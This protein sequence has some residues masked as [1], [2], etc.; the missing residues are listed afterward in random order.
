MSTEPNPE[1]LTLE[2]RAA[3]A[4]SR[5]V[6]RGIARL[7]PADMDLLGAVTGDI[8]EI[9]GKRRTVAKVMPAFKEHRGQQVLQIDGIIRD[10]AGI[11]L[12]DKVIAQVIHPQLATFVQLTPVS[13]APRRQ[14]YNSYIGKLIDGLAVIEGD[15]IRATMFG[16][17]F[18]EFK[19]N[20]TEPKGVVLIHPATGFS[21]TDPKFQVAGT[22]E[23]QAKIA[24]EDI[25]GLRREVE[26]LRELIEFPL[27]HPVIF[28]RLGIE[29][30]RGLL[31]SGPPG[32]GK[33]LI[34]RVIAQETNAHFISI[35][36]PEL[37]H[38]FYGESDV[39]LRQVFEEATRNQPAI[40][41]I[42]EIDAI[43]PK[44]ELIY[45]EIEKR[46]IGQLMTLMDGLRDR[47]QIIVIG[48]TNVPHA[49]NPALRRPG[50]FD[51]EIRLGI[52]NVSG[53]KEILEIHSRGMPLNSEVNLNELAS[54]T[55]GF[56]GADLHSL[57]REAA[58]AA[59]RRTILAVPDV[60]S[61]LIEEHLSRMRVLM[62]DFH[63]AMKLV[64]PSGLRGIVVEAPEV[65]W[66]QVGGLDQ[67]RSEL[68]R[69]VLFPL[70]H[71]EAFSR[72]GVRPTR[73]VLLT[74]PP[75]SGKTLVARALAHAGGTNFIS[76]RSS[77]L[78]VRYATESERVIEDIFRQARQAIPCI[79]FIDEIDL[80]MPG[81]NGDRSSDTAIQER[82]LAQL[83]T[84]LDGIEEL[85]GIIVIAATNRL[86]RIDVAL[87]RPGRFDVVQ[88]I[89]LPDV[90]GLKAIFEVYLEG[91]PLGADVDIAALAYQA[92]GMT[93]AD[94]E[95]VCRLA[96]TQTI[97]QA[98]A[99]GN[100][101]NSVTPLCF[102]HPILSEAIE[103]VR[104]M[105]YNKQTFF[106][107]SSGTDSQ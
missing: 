62:D 7:D 14:A 100:F 15:R 50:R 77:E 36:G 59:L 107:P 96:A 68:T 27:R 28:E 105:R 86:D 98:T 64:E 92:Q 18:Q 9:F 76:V 97:E 91:R 61:S 25:G 35:N 3:E 19:V 87:R 17:R 81:H 31:L 26:R 38:K 80:L 106:D 102:T 104:R 54:M 4:L 45:S 51:R 79:V 58:M 11:S 103:S 83:L 16:A 41:F 10:N 78:I 2:L 88:R 52:P 74:G 46:V 40:I 71:A 94:I 72:L 20:R 42:D 56:V 101:P 73:G 82:I 37:I 48:A 5:D 22:V 47:G 49:I 21:L 75:G 44:R 13:T 55:R 60:D 90:D 84:E 12:N 34:A 23:K 6:G 32:V 8:L 95:A 85:S 53:R 93:G 99:S 70:L 1:I 43:A 67:V 39:R 63:Q 69:A 65:S 89:P 29:P 24:Y 30:L 57:C 33:T 66:A